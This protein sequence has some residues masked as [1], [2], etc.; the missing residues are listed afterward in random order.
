MFI[1]DLKVSRD[2][3]ER[4]THAPERANAL[5]HPAGCRDGS[6]RSRPAQAQVDPASTKK[7]FAVHMAESSEARNSTMRAR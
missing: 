2:C 1:S 7:L 3:G 6:L 4:R 5:P